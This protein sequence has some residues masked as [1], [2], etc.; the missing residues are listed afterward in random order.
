MK[1]IAGLYKGQKRQSSGE[2]DGNGKG[3]SL[4]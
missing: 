2:L 4:E 3:K 1:L